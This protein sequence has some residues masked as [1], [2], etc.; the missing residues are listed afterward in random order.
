MKIT[1]TTILIFALLGSLVVGLQAVENAKANWYIPPSNTTLVI[2]SPQNV[3]Y[4]TNTLT[5]N[6]TVQKNTGL[7]SFFYSLD[8]NSKVAVE[9]LKQVSKV[10]LPEE[11]QIGDVLF[12]RY[13]KE[14]SAIL[15][16]LSEGLHRLTVYE[17]YTVDEYGEPYGH[18][19]AER[20]AISATAN[21]TINTTHN[22]QAIL[23]ITPTATPPTL[24]TPSTTPS[25][26]PTSAPTQQPT[27]SPK[28]TAR[29][30]EFPTWMAILLV[31][32]LSTLAALILRKKILSG[33]S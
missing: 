25:P 4:N 2:S 24:L 33:I 32:T 8:N 21:F 3:T 17:I 15:S 28:P 13:T 12:Y 31:A 7:Y 22:Q 19:I 29:V 27:L 23:T 9:N 20:I 14:G 26:L 16:N 6:F 30:P 18:R 1:L 11:Y 5:L 10:L